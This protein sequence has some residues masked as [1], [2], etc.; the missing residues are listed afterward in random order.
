[1]SGPGSNGSRGGPG[2][3][4]T[5]S[6]EVCSSGRCY[7]R[8]RRWPGGRSR[9]L[10]RPRRRASPMHGEL[11]RS[12]TQNEHAYTNTYRPDRA[13]RVAIEGKAS[14][15]ESKGRPRRG[16]FAERKFRSSSQLRPTFLADEDHRDALHARGDSPPLIRPASRGSALF[17]ILWSDERG[18][19]AKGRK[20]KLG[21]SKRSTNPR[22]RDEEGEDPVKHRC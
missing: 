17:T 18:D 13:K 15:L 6:H 11:P 2:R 5:R 4:R 21:W 19:G 12:A 22:D 16:K 14:Y 9:T 20:E 7:R 1:M 3:R 10:A 8:T